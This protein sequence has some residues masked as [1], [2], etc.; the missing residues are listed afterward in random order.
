MKAVTLIQQTHVESDTYLP[1]NSFFTHFKAHQN[2][3]FQRHG[4]KFPQAHMP[5]ESH[6]EKFFENTPRHKYR[7]I[8]VNENVNSTIE[9]QIYQS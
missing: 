4:N 5:D 7:D 3:G 8:S 6:F 2:R 9:H 1:K